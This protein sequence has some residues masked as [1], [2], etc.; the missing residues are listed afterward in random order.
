MPRSRP[1]VVR[2]TANA[3]VQA[4]G[5]GLASLIGLFTF[6]AVTRG[7]GPE[8]FGDFATAM[9][10]L[11]L[12][13]VLADVGIAAS[14]LREISASPERTDRVM[15]AA[16]PLRALIAAGAVG[17]AL[18]VGM[19]IPF[20]GQ[21]KTA[22]L[23]G[24]VGSF[25]HLMTLSLLPAI[26][27]ELKMHWAV[28]ANLAGRLLTLGFTLAALSAGFGFTSIVWAHVAGLA[29]TFGLH[30]VVVARLVSLRPLVDTAYWRS[31]LRGALVLGLAISLGQIYVRL[32]MLLLALLKPSAEVGLYGAAF[33]FIEVSELLV[34]AISISV[35]PSLARFVA[36]GDPRL[37][38]LIQKS[39]DVLI[40]VAA[41]MAVFMLTLSSQIIQ[42]TAGSKFSEASVAL[43]LLAPCVLFTFVNSLLI[44]VLLA[45][46]R[47]R[48]LLALA[49]ST[50][51]V[52]V[53]LNLL[54]I[55]AYG[56]RAAAA[57]SVVSEVCML[58]P[59]AL[60][61]R[62]LGALPSLRYV[63][64]VLLAV[65]GMAAVILLAPGPRLLVVALAGAVYLAALLLAPG[66]IRE[67]SR[68][69]MP[70]RPHGPAA[71]S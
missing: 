36:S 56:F 14:V 2:L 28:V 62:R 5:S 60:A 39:F 11:F 40:A 32:D 67:L 57:I 37:P 66:T 44:R 23:I 16:L 35:F 68:T 41:P 34:A 3:A 25:L 71:A 8:A 43:K 27:A 48:T 51:A 47:D 31:L 9:A 22:I 61:V 58:V 13:I 38:R 64:I 18:A 30:L 1:L 24:S 21:T 65:G 49:V 45:S 69:L 10:F 53:L 12:P 54:L 7:L 6:V 33:K 4:G 70:R 17:L 59:A 26:Q 20:S 19:A 63:P 50:L 46:N 55:P 29:V 42:L 52:N 15:S